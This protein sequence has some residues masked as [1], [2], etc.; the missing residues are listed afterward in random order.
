MIFLRRLAFTVLAVT[1]FLALHAQPKPQYEIYAIRYATL[2]AFAVSA[3]WKAP[4]H[5]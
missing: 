3:W 5:A 4:T 1:S 2:P